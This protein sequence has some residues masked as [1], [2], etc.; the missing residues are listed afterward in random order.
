LSIIDAEKEREKQGRTTLLNTVVGGEGKTNCS[1]NETH[2]LKMA[3]SLEEEYNFPLLIVWSLLY[4]RSRAQA[5]CLSEQKAK[6]QACVYI[7]PIGEEAQNTHTYLFITLGRRNAQKV[8][9]E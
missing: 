6:N 5:A 3:T 2:L 4:G 8:V 7:C 9:F 1:Q